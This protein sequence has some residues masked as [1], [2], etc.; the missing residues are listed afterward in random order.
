MIYQYYVVEIQ[1]YKDGTYGHIV[2]YAYDEDAE[3][4]RQKGDAKF[5]EVLAAAAVSELPKHSA[6]L[7]DTSGKHLMNK[8]YTHEVS[9]VSEDAES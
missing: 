4:A 8:S 5:Y 9:E 1:Q 6:I 2:H 3:K 7:F